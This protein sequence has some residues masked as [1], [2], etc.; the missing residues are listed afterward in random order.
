LLFRSLN[1]LRQI[2]Q[3]RALLTTDRTV[4]LPT[5]IPP[6]VRLK[7]LFTHLKS[8]SK[9]PKTSVASATTPKSANRERRERASS[10]LARLKL[11]RS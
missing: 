10:P 8:L 1:Q 6:A 3:E 9:H 7:P 11:T 2:Q 4:A 5:H